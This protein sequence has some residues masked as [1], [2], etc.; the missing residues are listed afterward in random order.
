MV[1]LHSDRTVAKL[2]SHPDVI[3][4]HVSP[5]FISLILFSHLKAM[6]ASDAESMEEDN[7]LPPHWKSVFLLGCELVMFIKHV[8]CVMQALAEALL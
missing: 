3:G 7:P 2:L 1:S 5:I 4:F 8:P 6:I